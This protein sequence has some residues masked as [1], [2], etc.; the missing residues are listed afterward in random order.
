M[1]RGPVKRYDSKLTFRIPSHDE[2][3]LK[4]YAGDPDVRRVPSDFARWLLQK[5]LDDIERQR[6]Q[7]QQKEGPQ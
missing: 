5:G 2:H 3:R 6:Q 4:M 7:R 1:K